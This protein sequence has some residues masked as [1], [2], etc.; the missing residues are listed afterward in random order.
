MSDLVLYY[1][2]GLVIGVVGTYFLIK[3]AVQ[4]GVEAAMLNQSKLTVEK[5]TED[6]KSDES[7]ET[8]KLSI[9]DK[10]DN[11]NIILIL[12]LILLVVIVIMASR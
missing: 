8:V 9:A 10:K 6:Q 1:F 3:T 11:N 5:S 12:G 7:P 4:K 2:I